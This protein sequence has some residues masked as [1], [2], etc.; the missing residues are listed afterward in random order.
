MSDVNIASILR[1]SLCIVHLL[2]VVI[3]VCNFCSLFVLRKRMRLA[4]GNIDQALSYNRLAPTF[5]T[6]ISYH[7]GSD[8]IW[9]RA[10]F[11]LL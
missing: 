9:R 10:L 8:R 7:A 3:Q 11:I 4:G 6:H 5:V 1:H 2:Q